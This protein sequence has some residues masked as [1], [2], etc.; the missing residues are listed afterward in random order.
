MDFA[1]E[2]AASWAAVSSTIVRKSVQLEFPCDEQCFARLAFEWVAT[3]KVA[4]SS[5]DE[6]SRRLRRPQTF[7]AL[8]NGIIPMAHEQAAATSGRV[9]NKFGHREIRLRTLRVKYGQ[10]RVTEK[11]ILR[12]ENKHG[13]RFPSAADSRDLFAHLSR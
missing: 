7:Q 10:Y 1:K 13:T 4:N 9:T 6:L 8:P 3:G 2:S 12:T 5:W 11:N